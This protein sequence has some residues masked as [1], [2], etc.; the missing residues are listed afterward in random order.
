MPA[1]VTPIFSPR[2]KDTMLDF[3]AFLLDAATRSAYITLAFGVSDV[4]KKYLQDNTANNQLIFMLLE[5]KDVPDADHPDT[6]IKINA[7]NNV[8]KANGAYIKDTLYQWTKEV[9]TLILG[10][11]LHVIYIHSKFMLI[12]PLSA[13]PIIVTGSANFSD[14]STTKN[15]ENMMKMM[16][17]IMMRMM[18]MV[19]MRK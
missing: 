1:G 9:N 5:K 10:L 7:S 14:A 13:D 19:Q 11:N 16:R 6:F 12:D 18:K 2:P 8:Y 17:M 4:F 3:Y 15:D